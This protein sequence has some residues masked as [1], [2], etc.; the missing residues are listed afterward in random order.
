MNTKEPV[1]ADVVVIG[2]HPY[3]LSVNITYILVPIVKL[4][5]ELSTNSYTQ[6]H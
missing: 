5:Q 1:S 2:L 6:I 3:M 4:L